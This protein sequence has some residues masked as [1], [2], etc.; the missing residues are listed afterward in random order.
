MLHSSSAA[1]CS[2][3]F[4]EM[5]SHGTGLQCCIILEQMA[6]ETAV[7]E[8]ALMAAS[9]VPGTP[10]LPENL[11]ADFLEDSITLAIREENG[12]GV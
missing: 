9:R 7:V 8:Y 3:S 1:G 10:H 12:Q 2:A 4:L 11:D 5:E 6:A